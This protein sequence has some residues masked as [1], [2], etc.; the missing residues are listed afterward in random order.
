MRNR[1]R[2]LLLILVILR[3]N[4]HYN[5]NLERMPL[6]KFLAL[7][8]EAPLK[9]IVPG[10][11]FSKLSCLLVPNGAIAVKDCDSNRNSAAC[12]LKTI[13]KIGA[14]LEDVTITKVG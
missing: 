2:N 7:R 1:L 11:P 6:N 5:S 8:F 3:F 10:F 9:S 12:N 13:S 14:S 4:T